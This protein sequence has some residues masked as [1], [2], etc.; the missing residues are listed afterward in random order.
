LKSQNKAFLVGTG[1]N[2]FPQQ[3]R[4][5]VIMGKNCRCPRGL[6]APATRYERGEEKG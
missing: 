6:S 4:K 1:S 5:K 3:G 2:I